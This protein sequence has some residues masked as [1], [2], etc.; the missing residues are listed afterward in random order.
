MSR[1]P[2]LSA[3]CSQNGPEI[4]HSV[5]HRHEIWKEDPFDVELIHKEARNVFD[6]ILKRATTPPGL[7]AGRIVLIL[8]ESGAG[9]THLMRA[10][11]NHVHG[12]ELG[13]VSYMQMTSTTEDY[14]R[15]VLGNTIDS[16]DH[17]YFETRGEDTGLK[18]L[19][20]GL[21][22]N[23]RL[24][25]PEILD[26][27]R[28]EL[29]PA[30]LEKLVR[31]ASN[32]LHLRLPGLA[33]IDSEV[34]PALLYLQHSH[35]RIKNLALRVLRCEDLSR[36]DRELI[37]G[38]VPMT[39]DTDPQRVMEHLGRLVWMVHGASM[40]ICLDQLEDLYTSDGESKLRFRRAMRTV[41]DLADR[42]PSS[43]IV[44]ACLEDFYDQLRD[45]LT[46]SML[47]RIEQDPVPSV[48]K[49]GRRENE[50]LELVS[51]RLSHLYEQMDVPMD[52]A[53]PVHPFNENALV[54]LAGQRTRDVLDAC[55][56]AQLESMETLSAP[57]LAGQGD[58]LQDLRIEGGESELMGLDDLAELELGDL[59]AEEETRATGWDPSDVRERPLDEEETLDAPEVGASNEPLE[60]AAE[61]ELPSQPLFETATR[62]PAHQEVQEVEVSAYE[63]DG[64]EGVIETPTPVKADEP[65]EGPRPQMPD[66]SSFRRRTARPEEARA[67]A[68][69]AARAEAER[70]ARV[71]AEQAARAEAEKA[72]RAEVEK[73]ARAEAEQAARAEA[74]K[75]A[76]RRRAAAPAPERQAKRPTPETR[77]DARKAVQEG[78]R[79]VLGLEQKWNDF[80]S[81]GGY[82]VPSSPAAMMNLLGW[83]LERCPDEMV[84]PCSVETRS[85]GAVVELSLRGQA[86]SQMLVIGLCDAQSRGGAL[87]RELKA[88][89][90]YV[91]TRTGVIVRTTAFPADGGD[92]TVQELSL[93]EQ[94]GWRKVVLEDSTW[95]AMAAMR[96]FR[97]D[98]GS[99]PEFLRWLQDHKPLTQLHGVQ[100][101]LDLDA[102]VADHQR[103]QRPKPRQ[104]ASMAA[105]AAEA[106][107][108]EAQSTPARVSVP[109]EM[110]L[111]GTHPESTK[112][113][114]ALDRRD[115]GRHCFCLAPEGSG[116]ADLALGIV[117]QVLAAR[118]PALV[119]D[120]SGAMTR[121][122][123]ERPWSKP[124]RDPESERLRQRLTHTV[125]PRVL[126]IGQNDT[127]VRLPV[128]PSHEESLGAL[129]RDRLHQD[130]AGAL[131]DLL[132]YGAR[133]AESTRRLI[134]AQAM[135]IASELHAPSSPSF[136][137]LVR[138]IEE[139]DPAFVRS[140]GRLDASHCQ[141]L[142][143]DLRQL[144]ERQ[145]MLADEGVNLDFADLLGLERSGGEDR[146]PLV[147]V[148][149][150]ALAPEVRAYVQSA[151]LNEAGRHARSHPRDQLQA[152]I[153][154]DAAEQ[155]LPRDREPVLKDQLLDALK[156]FRWAGLGLLLTS[157]RPEEVDLS[158]KDHIHTWFLGRIEDP[159][160]IA[161]VEA[162]VQDQR[163]DVAAG[164]PALKSGHYYL[165]RGAA[166]QL[167]RA[168]QP[169]AT[170]SR[171]EEQG[172]GAANA[173]SA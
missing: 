77:R 164:L 74:E 60:M 143:G 23:P 111:V 161:S 16:L 140:L 133:G 54:Q 46:R 156:R 3:F 37:G 117:E 36:I 163:L 138:L 87:M 97:Q 70:A 137:Q 17:P 139:R 49:A 153:W 102:L 144:A 112:E 172:N 99:R 38:L 130:A 155:A 79:Q 89:R 26:E 114:V 147:I 94:K 61:M 107:D 158:G 4:F 115:L 24:L 12:S 8:G 166:S 109:A 83:A 67:E 81:S 95:R 167:V 84:V 30:R 82:D 135:K 28:T 122:L 168:E 10:F 150:S 27:I 162:L 125:A 154:L 19:S 68:E 124:C 40:V 170:G 100:R 88:L 113:A 132:G 151:L 86:S 80:R 104:S 120:Q 165:L 76:S 116:R 44:V 108:K 11:R 71:E 142:A 15:Y 92:V 128:V 72:A 20:S 159:S 91:G 21:V 160:A 51:V 123:G 127:R 69:K 62:P 52:V 41:C 105:A 18:R 65:D 129:D 101:V 66:P 39:R 131:A 169:I 13:Y 31:K 93:L 141:R 78:E 48:L 118:V 35:P 57:V 85:H 6:R 96:R 64:D 90:A 47:D 136:A 56:K 5:T 145:P 53:E 173:A 55:R 7:A 98:H 152:L 43:I 110:I 121:V 2:R 14:P 146:V 50:I 34:L 73:A 149:T 171:S 103:R 134:L 42:V 106:E 9:K 45:G 32:R 22:G 148:D 126:R 59:G 58:G 1:D 157:E 33:G 29:V 119:F 75:A 63:E 25:E